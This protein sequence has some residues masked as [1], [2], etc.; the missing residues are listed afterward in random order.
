M[1]DKKTLRA[2]IIG[3]IIG[4]ICCFT[5]LLVLL[6]GAAGLSAWLGW[7]DYALFPIMYASMGVAAYGLYVRSGKIGG[8]PKEIISILVIA[9]LGLVFW[10]E[11]KFAIRI[12]VAAM[13]CVVVYGFYLQ[14]RKASIVSVEANETDLD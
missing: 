1:A 13:A 9:I 2:G 6:L 4:A 7:V 10:L 11:F 8:D 3:T 12:S 14:R 5:P